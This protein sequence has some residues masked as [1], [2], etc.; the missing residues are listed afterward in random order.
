[1]DAQEAIVRIQE[2]NEIH[3]RKERG[4]FRITEALNDAVHA[5]EKQVPQRPD[6]TV[7][8]ALAQYLDHAK[9]ARCHSMVSMA[10][11]YCC[12]C[13]QRIDWSSE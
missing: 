11:N 10:M 3:Q 13:G 4:A 2:H 1:M 12:N 8:D 6:R 7:G 9:C 5:L